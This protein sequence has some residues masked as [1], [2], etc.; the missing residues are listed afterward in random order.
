MLSEEPITSVTRG[1]VLRR[2]AKG[3]PIP[4]KHHSQIG[5]MLK[6][7]AYRP[8]APRT[9]ALTIVILKRRKDEKRWCGRLTG[10][11]TEMGMGTRRGAV[12]L[13]SDNRY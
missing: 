4:P 1:F 8:A 6:L 11:Y 9:T 10:V 7:R 5:A 12:L 13:G 2:R 3:W